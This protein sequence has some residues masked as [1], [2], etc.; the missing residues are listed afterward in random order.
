VYDFS[1]ERGMTE[2]LLRETWT[3]LDS[4]EL[5]LLLDMRIG[6]PGQ[7][8]GSSTS[9]DK[10]YLPLAGSS[11]RIELGYRDKKIITISQG[12][13]FDTVQWE[14]IGE[15][16]EKSILAGPLKVGREYSFSSFRVLGSWRGDSSGVQILPPP[17]YAPRAPMDMAEHPF[18][19]E[20][21]IRASEILSITYHRRLRE[22]RN[23][24]LLLNV[25]LRGRTNLQPWR[26]EHLW[27][28]ISYG[29]E[30][31]VIKWVKRVFFVDQVIKWVRRFFGAKQ[32]NKGFV[33][34]W[35]QRFFSPGLEKIVIDE[36]SSPAD[37]QVEEVAPEEYY[38][39]VGNDGKGLRV[40]ADLDQSI[41]LYTQLSPSNRIKF[42]RFLFW[43]DTASRQW[44][45]S[46]S[47]SFIC[48]V[49]AIESLTERGAIHRVYCEECKAL[50]Q[51]EVPGAT[52]RFRAFFE[53]Y[54]PG[55]AL[56]SRR[57]EM[58]SLRSGIVHG[59]ELMH[60]DRDL[61][62]VW[63]PSS[64]NQDEL[65]R[66]LWGLTRVAARSWLKNPPAT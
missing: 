18:I 23:L 41:C 5:R 52:E 19:L 12:P 7:Y 33:V 11:C 20:F 63:D 31:S 34:K 3:N 55:A 29:D 38:L 51:H 1:G 46:A 40:P 54:S 4:S 10:L 27:A 24:T 15:E 43:M 57:S 44:P 25:L 35:V 17:D 16:I 8:D 45:I 28:I 53:K 61:S 42:D 65:Q 6:G 66:E 50:R 26:A 60:L 48:L 62:F 39:A 32:Q 49:S 37:K 13:A 21:P 56:R 9:P 47:S 14:R 36:L 59:S 2:N 58:Y 64:L 22:H 30:G